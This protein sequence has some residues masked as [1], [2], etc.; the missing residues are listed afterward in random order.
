MPCRKPGGPLGS[1][2]ELGNLLTS[3]PVCSPQL[4][5]I[6]LAAVSP[7]ADQGGWAGESSFS[8]EKPSVVCNSVLLG[9]C[10]MQV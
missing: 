2:L 10:Q 1:S 5:Q 8:E 4:C 7:S 9:Q 3:V 6:C